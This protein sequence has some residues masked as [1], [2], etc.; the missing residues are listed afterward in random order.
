MQTITTSRGPL[1]IADS[2]SELDSWTADDCLE[3]LARNDPN[4]E[5]SIYGADDLSPLDCYCDECGAQEGEPCEHGDA[6][7]LRREECDAINAERKANTPTVEEL[8]DETFSQME[9]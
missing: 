8:R 6:C 5:W 4:G 7:S 2:R 3:W 9:G 1:A